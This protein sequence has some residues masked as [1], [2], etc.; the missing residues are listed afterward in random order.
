MFGMSVQQVE[1][2]RLTGNLWLRNRKIQSK[3]T[4]RKNEAPVHAMP[5]SFL[6]CYCFLSCA[7]S[8]CS[9]ICINNTGKI[10]HR[11]IFAS[12]LI[13]ATIASS[14][15]SDF[16]LDSKVESPILS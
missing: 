11:I 4:C 12:V 14:A 16:M 8:I 15:L 10:I 9:R 5:R 6:C 13:P 7:V 2:I 1:R 3:L